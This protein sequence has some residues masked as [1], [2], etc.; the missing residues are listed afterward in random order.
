M[1]R[2]LWR[3]ELETYKG[4]VVGCAPGTHAGALQLILKHVAAREGSLLARL[5]DAGFQDLNAVD[6]D[7]S[8]MKLPEVPVRRIDLNGPFAR[9]YRRKFK[10]IVCTD[11]IE[12]L[13]SPRDFLRQA[14]ELLEDDG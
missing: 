13:D 14:H 2:S 10:L 5:R 11:V 3:R 8:L 1:F 6:L 7:V 12:H 4:L 9:Y